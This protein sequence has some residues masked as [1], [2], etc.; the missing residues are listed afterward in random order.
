[1][2]RTNSAL[3]GLAFLAK[4]PPERLF[5]LFVDG[6][7]HREENG[8]DGFEFREPGCMRAFYDA[9]SVAINQIDKP[10][11]PDSLLALILE[12]HR[13]SSQNVRGRI[14]VRHPGQIRDVPIA[15]FPVKKYRCT[16]QGI[17]DI[18][19]REFLK[20]AATLKVRGVDVD[21]LTCKDEYLE[22][23]RYYLRQS[24]SLSNVPAELS[25]EELR[26]L[27][28]EILTTYLTSMQLATE[29]K[30][31]DLQIQAIARCA[32]DCELV[33]PFEDANGRVFANIML[34]LLLMQNGF[35]PA[36]F[37]EPNIF[38]LYGDEELAEAVKDAMSHTLFVITHPDKP[39]FAYDAANM[40]RQKGS[41]IAE[42]A[43]LEK[44]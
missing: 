13:A 16:K 4:L 27:I 1:M 34:D 39:L 15:A 40:R 30:N 14:G 44:R 43:A 23:C 8:Q 3:Y 41:L 33:H 5:Q 38:D 2:Q 17:I 11:T 37:F 7:V 22:K 6:D 42:T 19:K 12:I 29:Q 25:A 26:A 36:T 35:P 32:K 9:L 24:V 28:K 31:D 18:R 20:T 10:L 21:L